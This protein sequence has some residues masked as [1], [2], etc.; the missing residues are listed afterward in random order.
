MP[1]SDIERMKGIG[2]RGAR[3]GRFSIEVD[4]FGILRT[5]R[6]WWMPVGGEVW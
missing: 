6:V 2:G 3:V 1:L 5:D 4:F